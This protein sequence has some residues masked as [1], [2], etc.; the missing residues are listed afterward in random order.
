[1][2]SDDPK[3]M[4]ATTVIEAMSAYHKAADGLHPRTIAVDG[5]LPVTAYAPAECPATE[6]VGQLRSYAL[7]QEMLKL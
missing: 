3:G 6:G 2:G 4:N 5:S 1:M 7:Q